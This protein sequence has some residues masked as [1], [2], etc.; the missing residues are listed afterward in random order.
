RSYLGLP[1]S[2]E[3]GEKFGTLCAINDEKS[4]FDSRS[5]NL[6]QRIVRMFS[7]YLNL[8]HRAQRDTLT[9]LYNRRYLTQFFE[10]HPEKSGGMFYLDMDGFK[11]VNDEYGHDHGDSILKEVA[12]RLQAF[13][14]EQEDAFAVR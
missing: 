6:L 9:V 13:V 10:D 11:K 3:N 4:E 2:L 1:I 5:V 14:D 7:Y 8:E 12:L